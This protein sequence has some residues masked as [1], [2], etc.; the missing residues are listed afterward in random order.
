[1]KTILKSWGDAE[2]DRMWN[3]MYKIEMDIDDMDLAQDSPKLKRWEEVNS[4]FKQRLQYLDREK[5]PYSK[6][7]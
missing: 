5:I 7:R 2:L 6:N 1:M 4:Q 3:Q